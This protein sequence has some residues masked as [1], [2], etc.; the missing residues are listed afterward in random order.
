MST[1][2]PCP[3]CG[4]RAKFKLY[5]SDVFCPGDFWA[6]VCR[7]KRCLATVHAADDSKAGA[8]KIWNNRVP[9]AGMP[10]ARSKITKTM[11]RRVAKGTELTHFVEVRDGERWQAADGVE[12]VEEHGHRLLTAKA[13]SKFLIP[14]EPDFAPR[15]RLPLADE[16]GAVEAL[17]H[18]GEIIR[19]IC[20]GI[21][22]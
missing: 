15:V 13:V 19:I 10:P 16:T 2:L 4:S 20:K 5:K 6:V 17:D 21:H 14:D 22:A 18:D 12:H 1:L 7:N 8:L 9:T 11:V 3:F